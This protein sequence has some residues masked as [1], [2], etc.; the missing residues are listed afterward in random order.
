MNES[1][2]L[3]PGDFFTPPDPWAHHMH[4]PASSLADIEKTA[5]A[6][7]LKKVQGNISKAARILDISRT[8]LYSKME[9]HGL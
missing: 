5:I 9:K 2:I 6:N 1:G 3:E 4:V 8:T 7:A